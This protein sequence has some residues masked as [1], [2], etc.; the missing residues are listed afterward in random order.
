MKVHRPGPKKGATSPA[1]D[2]GGNLPFAEYANRIGFR[3]VQP[4][5]K[6]WPLYRPRYLPPV[7]YGD[8][9][10]LTDA[11]RRMDLALELRNTQLPAGRALMRGRL[12]ALCEIPRM[13]TYAIGAMINLAVSRMPHDHCFVNVG[14]WHG[15]TLLAGMAG[16]PNKTCIGVDN[17]SEFGGP[18]VEFMRRFEHHRSSRHLFLDLDYQDYFARQHEGP[19]GV[20]LYDGEHSYEHQLEG[21]RAAEPFFA[22]DCLV[23]V[24][25]TNLKAPRDA[26][27]DFM[28]KS[29]HEYRLLCDRR[30]RQNEH[31]TL[32]NGVIAVQ[33]VS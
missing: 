31:P 21:L 1:V 30:T 6:P 9:D 17:F 8:S 11:V 4:M 12:A 20:Y 3:F 33:R 22:E 32:W 25:D 24:D 19:I 29:D 10:P 23:L 28:R 27:F 5:R 7:R 2:P 14:V 16:N 26:L 15:F 13:S 18:R